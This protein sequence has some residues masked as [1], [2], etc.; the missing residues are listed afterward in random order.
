MAE[1]F[2]LR[3]LLADDNAVNQKVAL[4]MLERLGYRAD[5]AGNG[6]EVIESVAQRPYDVILM[7]VQMPEMDGVKATHHIRKHLLNRKQPCIIAM[8]AN[9][10]AGDREK[11]ISEGMDDYISK[12]VHVSELTDA[13]KNSCSNIQ[14]QQM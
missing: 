8:T 10:L 1:R 9:A 4:R 14:K 7:D 3:I 6:L 12:P 5:V 13:L 2:P 11:Y